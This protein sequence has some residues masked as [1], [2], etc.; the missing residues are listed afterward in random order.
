MLPCGLDTVFTVVVVTVVTILPDWCL[1][2]GM[3]VKKKKQNRIYRSHMGNFILSLK[4]VS[5][6]SVVHNYSA[7]SEH[8]TQ[9]KLIVS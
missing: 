9:W 5:M 7:L 6:Y 2:E 4:L 3:E 8:N 1:Q